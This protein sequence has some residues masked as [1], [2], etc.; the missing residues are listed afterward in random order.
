M[1]AAASAVRLAARANTAPVSSAQ[2]V[3]DLDP[4]TGE[5][6]RKYWPISLSHAQQFPPASDTGRRGTRPVRDQSETVSV[7]WTVALEA[8][9]PETTGHT[10]QRYSPGLNVCLRPFSVQ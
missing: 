9:R 7:A 3:R 8:R 10:N 4:R 2:P 6:P 1:V 5:A